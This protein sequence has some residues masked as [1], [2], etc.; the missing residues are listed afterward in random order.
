[1]S[2]SRVVLPRKEVIQ[3]QLPLALPCYDFTL[4]TDPAFVPIQG[5]RALPAFVV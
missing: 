2:T 1:M 3:D 5:L 4:I